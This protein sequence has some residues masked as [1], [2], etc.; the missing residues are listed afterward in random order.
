MANNI[1]KDTYFSWNPGA[2]I[3]ETEQ[4]PHARTLR[5]GNFFGFFTMLID[6]FRFFVG[7][8]GWIERSG[9]PKLK[10]WFS[11]QNSPI[12]A[13]VYDYLT[14]G[15]PRFLMSQ[16]RSLIDIVWHGRVPQWQG[17]E[18]GELKKAETWQRLIFLVPLL[19]LGAVSLLFNIPK[20]AAGLL[21]TIAVAPIVLGVCIG[22]YIAAKKDYDVLCAADFTNEA[23]ETGHFYK[24]FLR[25]S[26]KRQQ[27]TTLTNADQLEFTHNESLPSTPYKYTGNDKAVINA[28]LRFNVSNVLSE[29]EDADS[30]LAQN[31]HDDLSAKYKA[32][33]IA[34]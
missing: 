6:T 16:C 32:A 19:V 18:I 23:G 24:D 7:H 13:G 33:A 12:K 28:L 31:W 14:L 21:S 5:H 11:I 22:A 25:E 30:D 17:F 15:L 3:I 26:N 2:G 8:T 10:Q 29:L 34:V 4:S 20:Y 27:I 9:F 1:E